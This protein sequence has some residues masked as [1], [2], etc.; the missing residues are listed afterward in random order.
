MS[1]RAARGE[2]MVLSAGCASSDRDGTPYQTPSAGVT[3]AGHR[4][5]CPSPGNP[6]G[7][8]FDNPSGNPFDTAPSSSLM[9]GGRSSPIMRGRMCDSESPGTYANTREGTLSPAGCHGASGVYTSGEERWS[10]PLVA[11]DILGVVWAPDIE[12]PDREMHLEYMLKTVGDEH[13][14]ARLVQRR[15]RDF[16]KLHAA[17]LPYAKRAGTTVPPLPSNFT[18]FERKLSTEFAQQRQLQLKT[19]LGCI[20]A[21]APLWCDALRLFLGLQEEPAAA[22]TCLGGEVAGAIVVAGGSG[23]TAHE[24]AEELRWIAARAQQ[25]GCGVVTDSTGSFRGSTLVRWLTTQ[26]LVTSREQAVPLGDGMLRQGLIVAVAAG[27]APFV[28]GA[29]LFRFAQQ[30]G[31]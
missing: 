22:N 19:W 8:P 23:S 4:S 17:L 12:H 30:T 16:E 13:A 27:S 3:S 28:D 9:D 14:G 7:N 10:E 15:Y 18:F 20:V 29:A 2:V 6:F 21:R 11:V 5:D 31:D 26:A 1:W 24:Y 25:P